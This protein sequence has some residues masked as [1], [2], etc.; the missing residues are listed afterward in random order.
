MRGVSVSLFG[1]VNVLASMLLFDSC[2]AR[3][4]F[5]LSACEWMRMLGLLVIF[6]IVARELRRSPEDLLPLLWTLVL[7]VAVAM[8]RPSNAVSLKK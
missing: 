8:A 3:S 1:V 5:S 7:T 6:V 4:R 2:I